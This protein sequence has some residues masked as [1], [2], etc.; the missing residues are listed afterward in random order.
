MSASEFPSPWSPK[1]KAKVEAALRSLTRGEVSRA[2]RTIVRREHH[3]ERTAGEPLS[4]K[5]KAV[6]EAA[7]RRDALL[8]G[9]TLMRPNPYRPQVKSAEEIAEGRARRADATPAAPAKPVKK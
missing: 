7:Y 6:A 5:Q 1:G 8:R 3:A 9:E 4:P 2:L